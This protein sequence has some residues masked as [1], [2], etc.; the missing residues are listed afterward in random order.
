MGAFQKWKRP[1]L[2]CGRK[3]ES[4]RTKDRTIAESQKEGICSR[5]SSGKVSSI[6]GVIEDGVGNCKNCTAGELSFVG[7]VYGPAC[8]N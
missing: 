5:G 7:P 6:I 1:E 8:A 4:I 3:P 2:I